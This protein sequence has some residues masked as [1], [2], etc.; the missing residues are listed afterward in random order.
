M[1][2]QLCVVSKPEKTNGQTLPN[3]L[4]PCYTD[5]NNIEYNYC[6]STDTLWCDHYARYTECQKFTSSNE[7]YQFTTN[8]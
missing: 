3:T 7:G 8:T 6:P 4:S 5:D 2:R 1:F